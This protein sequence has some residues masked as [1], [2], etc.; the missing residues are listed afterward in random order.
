MLRIIILGSGN[1]FAHGNQYQSSH[2]IEFDENKKI[3]LDCGPAILQAI[4]FADVNIDDLEYLLISHLHGD[5]IAGIPFLLLH[6][7]FIIQRKKP[8]QII[9]P[10]GLKNQLEKLLDANY[11]SLLTKQDDLFEI[12]ELALQEEKEIFG[13]IRLKPFH[14]YHIPNAFG[15]TIVRD[16]IKVI[17]SGDNELKADQITEFENGSVLIHEMTTMRPIEGGHTS[18]DLLN[19]HLEEILSKVGKIIVVHTSMDV[20]N[21]PESTFSNKIIRARDGSMFLFN[22]KGRLYQ[23]IL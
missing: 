14:A 1:A 20:R 2:Y 23:M 21:E 4:Q 12:Q 19:E 9:G 16:G 17:Y 7:K 11:L 5:H 15:Y 6:Y 3:L 22:E 8:L 13:K 18:W 10:P